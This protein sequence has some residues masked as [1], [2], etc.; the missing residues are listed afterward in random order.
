MTISDVY[1]SAY[2]DLIQLIVTKITKIEEKKK[3]G[4][5]IIQTSCC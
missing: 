4:F 2:Q 1:F 5:Q 3:D